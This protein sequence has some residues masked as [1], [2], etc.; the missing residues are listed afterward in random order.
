MYKQAD[1]ESKGQ[2]YADLLQL[3]VQTQNEGNIRDVLKLF[4]NDRNQTISTLNII[5][6]MVQFNP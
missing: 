2:L 3:A 1:D 5:E 6:L 4:E